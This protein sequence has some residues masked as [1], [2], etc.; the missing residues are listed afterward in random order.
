MRSVS[1]L[2]VAGGGRQGLTIV[3]LL[4]VIAIIGL[5]VALLLPAVQAARESS[6]RSQCAN[7]LKQLGIAVLGYHDIWKVLPVDVGP[8][9]QGPNPAPQRNGKGWIVSILP[10]IEQEPLYLQFMP[11]FNGDFFS[12]GGL[13]SPVC[14]QLMKIELPLLHCPS[15]PSAYR[16]YTIDLE[17]Q[18]KDVAVTS[19]KGVLGDSRVGGNL[20][21]HPGRM[22]DCHINGGCTGLFYR[23]TY[24][25]PQRLAMVLDGTSNT[26]MLGEDVPEQNAASA[27]FYANGDWASCNG[28]LNYFFNPPQPANWWNVMTFRSRHPG[29]ANFC[30]ADGSVRFINDGID[31]VLYTWLSTKAEGEAASPP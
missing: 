11:C 30:L 4:V 9:K 25:E 31:Y 2:R 13:M 29:G 24:E 21:V 7:N 3:E 16:L 10:Q 17:W 26:F 27:A 20:S 22:P 18:G 28:Q 19:Y 6:R 12:G 8:F 1:R 15:D 23:V 14:Q 5:L